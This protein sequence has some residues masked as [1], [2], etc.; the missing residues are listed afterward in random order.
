[1][2]RTPAGALVQAFGDVEKMSAAY[3]PGIRW[4]MPASTP[5][6]RPM[7]GKDAVIAFNSKV[8]GEV[9]RPDC[10]VEILDEVGDERVSAARFIYRAHVIGK[11]GIYENEYTIFVRSGPEG[12]TEVFEAFDTVAALDFYRGKP[13]AMRG[14]DD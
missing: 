4:S 13:T 12:L 2:G 9:H 5:F 11:E 7:E 1:M 8:W 14:F 3:A 6:P 10:E